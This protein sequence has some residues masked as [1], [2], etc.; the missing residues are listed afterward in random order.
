MGGRY[1]FNYIHYAPLSQQLHLGRSHS[2][3]NQLLVVDFDRGDLALLGQQS[4]SS[5]GQRTVDLQALNQSR[6]GNQLHLGNLSLQSGPA[7]LIEQNLGV[8]LFSELS[9]VPLLLSSL[10]S[11]QSGGELLL[12]RLLL[13]FRSLYT[14]PIRTLLIR[15]NIMLQHTGLAWRT[16]HL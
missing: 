11:G 6:G 2:R 7:I 3:V 1:W 8:H 13:N 12:L 4:A 9:L 16:Y 10:T 14:Q 15:V 5:T